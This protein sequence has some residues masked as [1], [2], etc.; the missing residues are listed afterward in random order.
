M[1][2]ARRLQTSLYPIFMSKKKKRREGILLS[3]KWRLKISS[4][5]HQVVKIHLKGMQ[6]FPKS[7]YTVTKS[8]SKFQQLYREK[9]KKNP[10]NKGSY[11]N[12]VNQILSNNTASIFFFPSMYTT[13][14][15]V[16]YVPGIGDAAM[17]MSGSI[18]PSGAQSVGSLQMGWKVLKP[19]WCEMGARQRHKLVWWEFVRKCLL[20]ERQLMQAWVGS[21][22]IKQLG[23]GKKEYVTLKGTA[24]SKG[25]DVGENMALCESKRS[26]V[27]LL[28]V[29]KEMRRYMGKRRK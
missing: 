28:R 8:A 13:L 4:E 2:L 12:N 27:W 19:W 21:G 1:L 22:Q 10:W 15:E 3:S 17:N 9:K 29:R 7:S 26:R 23:R 18:N 14:I 11:G 5:T 16:S 6:Y 24:C 20:K 25:A